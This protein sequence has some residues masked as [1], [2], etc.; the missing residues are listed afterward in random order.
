MF[1]QAAI[2]WPLRHRGAVI[3]AVIGVVSL[4]SASLGPGKWLALLG[5]AR[6]AECQSMLGDFLFFKLSANFS[7]RISQIREECVSR[8]E[9]EN[10]TKIRENPGKSGS[11]GNPAFSQ[12]KWLN[13]KMNIC[14]QMPLHKAFIGSTHCQSFL[15]WNIFSFNR[16]CLLMKLMQF[17]WSKFS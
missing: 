12:W 4:S 8:R 13:V 9:I 10:F 3:P 2:K 6:V 5:S 11:V 1:T 16:K 17:D 14:E 7:G 15:P